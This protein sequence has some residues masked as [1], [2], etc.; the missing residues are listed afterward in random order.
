MYYMLWYT[1]NKNI[2][3]SLYTIINNIE[4]NNSIAKDH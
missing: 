2:Y 4:F 3:I 1:I